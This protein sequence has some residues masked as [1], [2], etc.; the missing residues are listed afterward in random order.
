MPRR[1][2]VSSHSPT[3]CQLSPSFSRPVRAQALRLSI[4]KTSVSGSIMASMVCWPSAVDRSGISSP[5]GSKSGVKMRRYS[6]AGSTSG[7]CISSRF[8]ISAPGSSPSRYSTLCGR[9][10]VHFAKAPPVA[11]ANAAARQKCVLPIPRDANTMHRS[12]ECSHG[13]RIVARGLKCIPASSCTDTAHT[14]GGAGGAAFSLRYA[15]IAVAALL[16]RSF[17]ITIMR[18]PPLRC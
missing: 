7:Q 9:G 16:M 15:S 14:G 10:A 4:N 17:S 11:M 6:G 13:A 18:T 12:C 5:S 3:G 8:C 1:R 2:R